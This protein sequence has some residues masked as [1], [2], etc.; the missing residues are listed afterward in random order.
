MARIDIP[1]Q[2]KTVID[3][4][5]LKISNA[6]DRIDVLI[7]LV[8]N[9]VAPIPEG[10]GSNAYFYQQGQTF[11]KGFLLLPLDF[12]IPREEFT[13]YAATIN[14][15]NYGNKLAVMLDMIPP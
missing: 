7:S 2:H 12:G 5:T 11:I 13:P 14:A 15:K 1:A 9:A 4:F 3:D 10:A 8:V 6:K